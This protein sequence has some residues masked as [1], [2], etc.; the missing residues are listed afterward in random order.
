MKEFLKYKR[1][2]PKNTRQIYKLSEYV[3]LKTRSLSIR[4]S[5]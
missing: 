5:K 4:S 2:M 3:R 1:I